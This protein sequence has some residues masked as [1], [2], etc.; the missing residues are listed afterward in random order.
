MDS[1]SESYISNACMHENNIFVSLSLLQV[2]S[3][4]ESDAQ[5]WEYMH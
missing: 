3:D 4:S 5:V 2:Y 1:D